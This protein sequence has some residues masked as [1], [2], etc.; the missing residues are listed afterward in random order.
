MLKKAIAL[1]CLL[2]LSLSDGSSNE[3]TFAEIDLDHNGL[4][5]QSE[6]IVAFKQSLGGNEE[7]DTDGFIATLIEKFKRRD[8]DGVQGLSM[9]EMFN[10]PT[11]P[12]GYTPEG[13]QTGEAA[14]QQ[15][16]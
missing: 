9:K 1:S 5:S 4:I 11:P 10:E 15:E 12:E 16:L 8:V 2:F 6:I 14:Q 3:E 13:D 7:L